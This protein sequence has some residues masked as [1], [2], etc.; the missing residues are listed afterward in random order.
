MEC[1][2]GRFS[3]HGPGDGI[4]NYAILTRRGVSAAICFRVNTV[5]G[6]TATAIKSRGRFRANELRRG[7]VEVVDAHVR[8]HNEGRYWE[9][10]ENRSLI[11][12]PPLFRFLSQHKKIL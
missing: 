8:I 4:P 2:A 7:G 1:P 9:R 12:Q 5:E 10:V 3:G 11:L 6:L